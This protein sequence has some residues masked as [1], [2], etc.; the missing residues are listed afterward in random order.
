MGRVLVSWVSIGEGGRRERERTTTRLFFRSNLKLTLLFPPSPSIEWITGPITLRQSYLSYSNLTSISFSFSSRLSPSTTSSPTTPTLPPTALFAPLL[1]LPPP[2]IFPYSWTSDS[3]DLLSCTC[4]L[5]TRFYDE[6]WCKVLLK[7]DLE[8]R[9]G[10][11]GDGG[12]EAYFVSFWGHSWGGWEMGKK[13]LGVFGGGKAKVSWFSLS[14]SC[15]RCSFERFGT[16]FSPPL[17]LH[18]SCP[19]LRFTASHLTLHLSSNIMIPT[20]SLSFVASTLGSTLLFVRSLGS[21]GF[22]L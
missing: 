10:T 15:F 2:N 20:R 7:D 6:G 12:V 22:C 17:F 1:L 18:P 14:L 21:I 9:Y 16:D 13:I 5:Q 4:S 19:S 8:T 3:N 11:E